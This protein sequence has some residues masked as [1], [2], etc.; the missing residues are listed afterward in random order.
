MEQVRLGR[1]GP[2]WRDTVT[3]RRATLAAL[4]ATAC[5]AVTCGAML[6]LMRDHAAAVDP[7]I[8]VLAGGIAGFAAAAL[9]VVALLARAL[10]RERAR[11]RRLDELV[12]LLE[13]ALE[14][15]PAGV[16]IYDADERLVAFN[17]AA[18][19][20]NPGLWEPDCIGRTYATVARETAQ[21]LEA[22]GHG[23]QPVDEWVARFRRKDAQRTR[24]APDGRWFEWS[25]RATPSGRTVGL[26]V[27]V[28]EIKNKELELERA[29]AR[30][31]SLVDSLTDMVYATNEKGI[32]TYASPGATELLGVPPDVLIG[33]RFRDWVVAEDVEKVIEAGRDFHRSPNRET[34]QMKFR[35]KAANGTIRPVE[36]RYRKSAREDK[37]DV[38]IGVIR[39][40][41]ALERARL[42]YQSLVD[43]LAD[44]AYTLDVETG[45]FTFVSASA[46]EFFGK[47]PEAMVGT[48]YLDIIAPESRDFVSRTTSRT[49]DPTDPGTLSRFCMI[50]KG[51]EIR[52]VEV[53]ARRRI[54]ER[55]RVVSTGL[56]RDVEE[57]ERLERRIEEQVVA[58]ERARGEYQS[59]VNSLS[60][61]VYNVDVETGRITF[62][63]AAA[64]DFF[65]APIEQIVGTHFLDRVDPE[66]HSTL[67]RLTHTE[68]AASG[69]SKLTRFRM[70]A[71]DGSMRHVEARARHRIGENGRRI[72]TGVIRDVER[73]V[74]L[75]RRLQRETERLRSIVESSGA[76]IV[77]TDRNLD[78]VM[79]NLGFTALTGL[80]SSAAIGRPLRDVLDVSIDGTLDRPANFAVTLP[81]R[82]GQTRFVAVTATPVHVADEGVGNI[83]LVGVDETER[84]D[85]EGALRDADRFATIGEMA[86]AMAHEI[87]QPLQV[88]NLA[89]AS[90]R[91]EL[92]D[93]IDQ[94]LQPDQEYVQMKLDRIAQQV[95]TASRIVGDLRA[96]VRGTGSERLQPFSPAGAIRNAVNLTAHSMRE[97]R[98]LLHET[99]QP[100]L[101]WVVGDTGRL[102]QV[103]VNLLNNARDADGRQIEIVADTVRQDD[104]PFVRIAVEDSGNGIPA[105]VLP[106]LFQSFVTG[107]PRGKGTG[108]GLRVCRRIIEEM[109]GSIAAGNRPQGGARFEILLPALSPAA[110][111]PAGQETAARAAAF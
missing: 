26:R 98:T 89:C 36:L 27:D 1:P 79:V 81:G 22:A 68:A 71:A 34:R 100:D 56:I 23:P 2:V 99:V 45:L 48:H 13:E 43:A 72:V 105:G 73:R 12:G 83:V 58:L 4:C 60:D 66:Y 74:Q 33:T 6:S 97:A 76:L 31:H 93:A 19:G 5:L 9:V 41:S 40:I 21:R 10:V 94:G 78:V 15:L 90:A 47:S 11:T 65:G 84:H 59:L 109:G 55:G 67:E 101:P 8:L 111:F 28:T 102:E 37:F 24:Q 110:A 80:E 7:A 54:D 92:S 14:V 91:D 38:Q 39:D 87:S 18:A 51:G 88:I 42:E 96:F 57:R 49:Y 75:E 108:L 3:G 104:R 106:H 107:K 82:D 103:L 44:V 85:A 64:A 70:R 32:F 62:A 35:M 17:A 63:N 95:E 61:L 16:V 86:G 25:E 77:L 53:R 46:A 20:V 52:H 50:A 30:Y 69:R 29:G